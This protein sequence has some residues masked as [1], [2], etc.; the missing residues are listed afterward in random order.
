MKGFARVNKSNMGFTLVELIISMAIL[1]ILTAIITSIM[2]SVYKIDDV[3]QTNANEQ[4]ELLRLKSALD[5]IMAY[6]SSDHE[7]S[8]S[9]NSIEIYNGAS[10]K[11]TIEFDINELRYGDDL[12][13]PYICKFTAL[14][15]ITF[16]V[17]EDIVFCKAT[18]KDVSYE[19]KITYLLK[20]AKVKQKENL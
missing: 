13:K 14:D 16:S 7:F 15:T 17:Y 1:A 20:A 11:Y 19:H 6:D 18:L 5:N 2:L 10:I 4:N 3:S 9:D 8:I 12:S